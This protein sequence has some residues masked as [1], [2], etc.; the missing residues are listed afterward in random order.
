MTYSI[1]KLFDLRSKI[2]L[3]HMRN[4]HLVI[5]RHYL[6]K[7]VVHDPSNDILLN[8]LLATRCGGRGG[9]AQVSTVRCVDVSMLVCMLEPVPTH[10][11]L[12]QTRAVETTTPR[13]NR[14]CIAVLS[15]EIAAVEYVT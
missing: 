9:G 8:L 2:G 15:A 6:P 14:G 4:N 13:K 3:R 7:T 11:V 5:G 12:C 10:H 1:V